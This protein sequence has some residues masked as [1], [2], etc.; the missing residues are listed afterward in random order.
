MQI[1]VEDQIN[2]TIFLFQQMHRQL[3]ILEVYSKR[4]GQVC[5]HTVPARAIARDESSSLSEDFVVS[6]PYL[7]PWIK[8]TRSSIFS[9]TG[10][11][12]SKFLALYGSTGW[13]PALVEIVDDIVIDCWVRSTCVVTRGYRMCLVFR[14]TEI[15]EELL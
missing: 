9:L 3:A 1:G 10:V 12:G 5:V 6:I 11:S 7:S 14:N 2:T 13:V 15:E 8:A 4:N